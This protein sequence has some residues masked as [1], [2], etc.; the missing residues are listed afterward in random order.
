MSTIWTRRD[1]VLANGLNGGSTPRGGA[2][3]S[4]V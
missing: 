4:S 1:A 2:L 3:L